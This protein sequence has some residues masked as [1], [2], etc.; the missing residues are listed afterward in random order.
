M[1]LL[2]K[3]PAP[4][5]GMLDEDVGMFNEREYEEETEAFREEYDRLYAVEL[6]PRDML[7]PTSNSYMNAMTDVTNILLG[8]EMASVGIAL[9]RDGFN[10]D[11]DTAT[12]FWSEH[13]VRASLATLTTFVPMAKILSKSVKAGKMGAISDEMLMK[14]DFG[15]VDDAE[16]LL[17]MGDT[18]KDILKQQF[19]TLTQRRDLERK[20]EL[21]TA[22]FKDKSVHN[23]HK[24][25]GN[26]YMEQTDMKI[27]P[28]AR[29]EWQKS[30]NALMD[31]NGVITDFLKTMPDDS[32]MG[33]QIA[34]YL[35]DPS[36][37]GDIPQKYQ[38]WAVR[39]ADELRS[40]QS[41]MIAEGLISQSEAEHVGD[42]WFSMTREGTK[43]DMG[44][45]TTIVERTA[46][47]E[48]RVLT[49]PRTTSPNL[50][51]RD[52][53]RPQIKGFLEKQRSAEL[54]TEGKTD[55][56]L[57]MLK[58]EGYEDVRQLIEEGNKKGAIKL[59]SQQGTVDFSPKELTFNTLFQ[60]KQLL[61][62]YRGLRDLAMNPDI[63]KSA[64]FVASMGPN[65]RKNWMNLDELD[66]SDR[67]RRMVGISTGNEIEA[68]GYVPKKLFAEMKEIVGMDKGNW[69]SGVGDLTQA[70]VAM[71]KTAKTAFNLPTHLQNSLGNDFFLLA[72]GV[73]P[74]S[75]NFWDLK[76]KS[77]RAIAAMQKSRRK[78][79]SVETG[80]KGIEN[81]KLK[82]MIGKADIDIA[83]E[84]ASGEL[85]DLLELSSM[86]QTEGIG[87]LQNIIK[88]SEHGL[89]KG[90][91]NLYNKAIKPL[92]GPQAADAYMRE[93]G[94]AKLA[95]FLHLRQ[96]GLSRKAC[97][98][99][100]GRSL[101][102]YN[103]V[104]D[105]PA[106]ARPIALPWITFP[107]EATRIL[108]NNLEDHPIKA[109]MMLQLPEMLQLGSYGAGRA[110]L[111]G[112]TRMN[113]E[114]IEAKKKQ[115]P[116]WAHR[117]ASF[118][119]P[120][121][122]KNGD[123]RAMM[124]DWLPYASAMPPSIADEAPL[125]KKMPFGMDEPMPIMGAMYYALTGKDAWGREMPTEGAQGKVVNMVMNTLALIS[126]PLLSQYAFNSS[127]P[128]PG[129][130]LLQD[131]GKA[132]NPYTNKEGDPLLDFIGNRV[133]GLK[134]YAASPEQQLAN[135][136]FT[137]KDLRSLRGRYTREWSALLKSNDLQSAAEKMQAV[138]ATF[139]QEYGNPKLAQEKFSNWLSRHYK[140]LSTHPQLRGM[141]RE[142]LETKINDTR[143]AGDLRT[144][145]ARE[146]FMTY[147]TE[148]GRRGRQ[149]NGGRSNPLLPGLK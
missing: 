45:M 35:D 10:F 44:S 82:S 81:T 22:T 84:L 57:D 83:E 69:K 87:V 4:E 9:D 54:L 148:L 76:K 125:L 97:L 59:L 141:S 66:G 126:P 20:I 51:R 142:E 112:A 134:S 116:T 135:E 114:E 24:W 98:N 43:R 25:F 32:Q 58:G 133:I 21:G 99:E 31:K 46:K 127:E 131:I 101:P 119:T 73:N 13:P 60:Q 55:E 115:L 52:M 132:T 78:G 74:Y 108:K 106:Q 103:T 110:G 124:M 27:L 149:S 118:M 94:M 93:D 17:R 129:Y 53:S 3:K 71:Y 33:T 67:L 100:V 88:N 64:D 105:I 145:A 7:P 42:L 61:A 107:V 91:V 85:T 123:F 144:R 6:D 36:T 23:L 77:W 111:L 137:K 146:M 128:E 50:L 28:T 34:R 89:T 47:G 121:K 48:P 90:F 143:K 96:R 2:D 39:M 109:M 113:A 92:G 30:M 49:I 41:T 95:Y 75:S 120:W 14:T 70:I 63:T 26:S 80:I 139:V 130:K 1:P 65:A 102:M 104:G 11:V 122:D 29:L 86:L 147:Q 56:A 138:H 79:I 72:R 5:T 18:E 38:S 68:L 62:T 37:L 16:D 8:D 40:E 136:E 140:D 19:N 117:P 15:L 12:N